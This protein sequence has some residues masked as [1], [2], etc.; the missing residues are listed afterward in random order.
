MLCF[1]R[2]YRQSSSDLHGLTYGR[3]IRG[4]LDK[5]TTKLAC[6]V[7]GKVGACVT[8]FQ[9]CLVLTESVCRGMANDMSLYWK[10]WRASLPESRQYGVRA[11]LV[12]SQTRTKRHGKEEGTNWVCEDPGPCKVSLKLMVPRLF[13]R[14]TLSD[15]AGSRHKKAGMARRI[16]TPSIMFPRYQLKV[17]TSAIGARQLNKVHP[18]CFC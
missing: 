11:P 16:N 4:C 6:V 14:L 7:D 8:S 3:M 13:P 5:A 18:S 1:E 17:V 10:Y 2:R 12:G 9:P 15:A